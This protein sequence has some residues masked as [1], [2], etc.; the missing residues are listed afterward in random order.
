MNP[1]HQE[2]EYLYILFAG[3]ITA[4]LCA[5]AAKM[6]G[7]I[8]LANSMAGTAIVLGIIVIGYAARLLMALT[9]F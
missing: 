6:A 8:L 9:R 1:F 4:L 7:I 5:T 3:H 2:I